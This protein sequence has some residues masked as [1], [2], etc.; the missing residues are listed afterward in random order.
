MHDI[1]SLVLIIACDRSPDI[2][3]TCYCQNGSCAGLNSVQVQ[4]RLSSSMPLHFVLMKKWFSP[5]IKKK[6]NSMQKR[7]PRCL[8]EHVN[9]YYCTVLVTASGNG[10]ALRQAVVITDEL[11]LSWRLGTDR[12]HTFQ[13]SCGQNLDQDN[14]PDRRPGHD[15]VHSRHGRLNS[16][17]PGGSHWDTD[18]NQY[19]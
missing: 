4:A 15:F 19:T 10:Q 11:T 5:H 16:S 18:V 8:K 7:R 1:Y 13:R 14:A 12:N 9:D 2:M 17:N 3:P 6:W